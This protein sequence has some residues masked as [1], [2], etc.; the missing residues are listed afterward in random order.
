ML[1]GAYLTGLPVKFLRQTAGFSSS[2]G[3][4]FLPRASHSPP[5]ELQLQIW[6]WV[7]TW[8][9]RFRQRAAHQDWE[10]G[11]LDQTDVAGHGFLALLRHLRVVLLQDLAVL[12]PIYPRLALFTQPVFQTPEWAAFAYSVQLSQKAEE[13]QSLLLQQA[14]PELTNVLY[15]T[16]EAVLQ[17][18]TRHHEALRTEIAELKASVN[19]I[20]SGQIPLQICGIGYFGPDPTAAVQMPPSLPDKPDA[21]AESPATL[22]QLPAY[23]LMDLRTVADAWREWKEGIAGFPAVEQLESSWGAAWRPEAKQRVAFCRR[24]VVWDE[25]NRLI[26]AGLTQNDAVAQLEGLRGGKSLYKLA[27]LLQQ[28]QRAR[29]A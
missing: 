9:E 29:G 15:S 7:G 21:A 14:V 12:Q 13:P 25:V 26:Q 22:D 5:A 18:G 10:A 24:K 28:M 16:R 19:A 6:P 23:T 3:A 11:G 1:T 8:E 2:G 27:L 17:Q 4:Y 20:A